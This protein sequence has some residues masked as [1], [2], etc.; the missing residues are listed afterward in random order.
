MR[1]RKTDHSTI[2][3]DVVGEPVTLNR[4]GNA[5]TV[6]LRKSLRGKLSADRRGYG[7]NLDFGGVSCVLVAPGHIAKAEEETSEEDT[8]HIRVLRISARKYIVELEE[9]DDEFDMTE[10]STDNNISKVLHAIDE[11]RREGSL[12]FAD[13]D[14]LEDAL[15]RLDDEGEG[16]VSEARKRLHEP[17]VK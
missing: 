10:R 16:I 9:N 7:A 1:D 5:L 3:G 6:S 8:V 11:K 13:R 2:I 17:S 12:D 14:V 15:S 4:K